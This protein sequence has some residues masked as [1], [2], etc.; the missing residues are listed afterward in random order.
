MW[1]LSV[2]PKRSV[3]SF[4]PQA[5]VVVKEKSVFD[6]DEEDNKEFLRSAEEDPREED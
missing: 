4:A 6:P 1:S 5:R 2:T 3:V